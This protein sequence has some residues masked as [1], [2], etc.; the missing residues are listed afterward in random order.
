MSST[1][2]TAVVLAASLVASMQGHAAEALRERTIQVGD[3]TLAIAL[4]VEAEIRQ[5]IGPPPGVQIDFAPGRRQPRTIDLA[6]RA[7]EDAIEAGT[8][9]TA[10]IGKESKI[11]YR[12]EFPG[13]GSGGDEGYLI[14]VLTLGAATFA[15]TCVTQ[16]EGLRRGDVEWCLEEAPPAQDCPLATGV[17]ASARVRAVRPRR[18]SG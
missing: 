14:G 2:P 6:A 17:V 13:G 4:P 12:L 7:P 8:T 5:T 1:A 3:T 18:R 15:V 9:A 11:T 10:R 16:A